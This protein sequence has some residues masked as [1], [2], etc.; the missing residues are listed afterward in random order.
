MTFQ[1]IAALDLRPHGIRSVAGFC[2]EFF[3]REPTE[4]LKPHRCHSGQAQRDQ[5]K[6]ESSAS[7]REAV[8]D[9][10][11]DSSSVKPLWDRFS[12]SLHNHRENQATPRPADSPA[13]RIH[14]ISLESDTLIVSNEPCSLT[15][16]LDAIRFNTQQPRESEVGGDGIIT[17]QN[18]VQLFWGTVE[19]S[20]AFH[21]DDTICNDKV[22]TDRGTNID[23]A[24]VNSDPM[25]DIL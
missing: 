23:N 1:P 22:G 11:P 10:P 6:E 5:E 4:H 24:F 19:R 15:E 20:V 7:L 25:K 18:D 3:D 16:I 12:K 17:Q 13:L 9:L 8:L 2:R 14:V 21:S